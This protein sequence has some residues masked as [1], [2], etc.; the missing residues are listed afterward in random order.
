[1]FLD[2]RGLVC[3]FSSGKVTGIFCGADVLLK[4]SGSAGVGSFR[5]FE[6]GDTVIVTVAVVTAMD[7]ILI[8]QLASPVY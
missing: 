5:S 2:S 8:I 1:M 4:R 3:E 6:E 7:V